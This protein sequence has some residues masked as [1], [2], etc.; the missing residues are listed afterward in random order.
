MYR[1]V[2]LFGPA[3]GLREPRT[4]TRVWDSGQSATR[5][6][7][8]ERDATLRGFVLRTLAQQPEIEIV[9]AFASVAEVLAV[10]DLRADVLLLDADLGPMEV[11]GI[12]LGLE[13][14]AR[15]PRLGVVLFT[16]VCVPD[17]TALLPVNEQRG[18]SIVR[19]AV[20]MDG[21]LLAQTLASTARGLNVVDPA[22]TRPAADHPSRALTVRQ[23]RILA[24]AAQGLDGKSIAAELGLAAITVRQELSRAYDVLVPDAREGIDLRTLAVVRYLRSTAIASDAAVSL[25]G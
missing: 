18:W 25:T 10:E 2:R 19:K 16:Q 7:Y 22:V 17:L 13:L 1:C 15:I 24:L 20:E 4:V 14:R 9:A 8:I 5:V 12:E 21:A 11:S 6:V 3:K 23:R